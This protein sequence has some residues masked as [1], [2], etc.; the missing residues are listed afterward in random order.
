M[1]DNKQF[2]CHVRVYDIA[3]DELEQLLE[4]N[5]SLAGTRDWLYGKLMIWALDHGKA[6]E[7]CRVDDDDLDENEKRMKE[8]RQRRDYVES[9]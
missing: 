5:L 3:T 6:V 2:I 7:I 4:A 1:S 9:C 8:Q